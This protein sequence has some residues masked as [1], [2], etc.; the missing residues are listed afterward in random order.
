[1]CMFFN[2]KN[3]V[4]IDSEFKKRNFLFNIINKYKI[5]FILIFL[6]ISI[7]VILSLFD[8]NSVLSKTSYYLELFGDDEITLYIGSD[9]IESGYNAYNDKNEDMTSNVEIY[10]NLDTSTLGEYT[11]TYK[12]DDVTKSRKVTVIEKGADNVFL[13]LKAINNDVNVYLK[14]NDEYI[15]PGYSVFSS[16]GVNYFDDVIVT[17][18]VDTSKEGNYKLVYSLIDS[19]GVTISVSRTIIVMDSKINLS[20]NSKEYT[21]QD[22]IINVSV[23]DSYFDYI[24]FPDGTKVNKITSSYKVSKNGVYK[25]VVYNKKGYAKEA[26]IEVNNIDKTLPQGSCSGIYEN[27]ISTIKI[28]A[29]DDVGIKKYVL[30]NKE[31]TNNNISVNEKIE[32]AN[33]IIYDKAGNTKDISCSVIDNNDYNSS[34]DFNDYT[35]IEDNLFIGDSRTVGMCQNYKLCQNFEYIAKVGEGY[36]WFKNTAIPKINEKINNKNYNIIIL[37]GVNGAG[38]TKAQGKNEAIKYYNIVSSLAT[39]TWKDQNIIF[40]SVNPV[41]DGYSYTYTA[42]VN[43]FNDEM[44]LRIN[45]SKIANLKYCDTNSE[46]TINKSNASDGLHYNKAVYQQIYDIIVSKCL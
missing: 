45:E 26:S 32:I 19:N 3:E 30:N 11:I 29:S 14:L 9:Y 38:S 24:L 40:V 36:Y 4:N 25:F 41:L 39:S 18:N 31:Y 23:V 34:S 7:I 44:K 35:R 17:G 33:I 1:M 12:I 20:L 37:M 27:G 10:S 2:S 46:L 16:T 6:I 42:A 8:N 28:S 15:E 22:V 43:S 21:N 13:Y 5:I